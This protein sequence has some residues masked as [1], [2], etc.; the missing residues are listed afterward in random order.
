MMENVLFVPE[1]CKNLFSI[2]QASRHG[3]QFD[4]ASRIGQVVLAKDN[5]SIVSHVNPRNSLY[6]VKHVPDDKSSAEANALVTPPSF[7]LWHQRLGHPAASTMQSLLKKKAVRGLKFP[8]VDISKWVCD[9]C[10]LGNQKKRV[11]F[12]LYRA[13]SFHCNEKVHSDL[14]GPIEVLSLTGGKYILIFV[15]RYSRYIHVHILNE[16]SETGKVIVEQRAQIESKHN[17]PLANLHTDNGGE[18]LDGQVAA[19]CRREGIYH[20]TT[21]TM[22]SQQNGFAK[23]RF[24]DILARA[25]AML[26]EAD[27][28]KQLWSYAV[29]CAVYCMNRSV[30]ANSN[31]TPF[32]LWHGYEPD[33]S[34]MKVFGSVC[35]VHVP[36]RI[37][38]A[39]KNGNRQHKRQKLDIRSIR[40]IFVGY[41]ESKHSY[42]VLDCTTGK[43][44]VSVHITFDESN[45]PAAKEL[46]RDDLKQLARIHEL[47]FNYYSKQAQ[48]DPDRLFHAD[49][50]Q[51]LLDDRE[52]TVLQ[53]FVAEFDSEVSDTARDE[54]VEEYA[55]DVASAN[56][57]AL[58]NATFVRT[59]QLQRHLERLSVPIPRNYA[60]AKGSKFWP[61]WEAAIKS[62][63]DALVKTGTWKYVCNKAKNRLLS[64]TWVFR[65]KER[66]DGSIERF[67]A[68]LV[69]RGYMQVKGLDYSEVCAPVVRLESLRSLLA[70]ANALGLKAHQMDIDTAFLNGV[71][72]ERIGIKLPDGFLDYVSSLGADAS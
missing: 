35:Y 57:I 52:L 42:K 61:H 3:I 28:P 5:L 9:T 32:K 40:G 44:L 11:M 67:K 14:C 16:K 65:A 58:S 47:D 12:P 64:T 41:A 6:I 30:S 51:D 34:H 56:S 49:V 50:V 8:D 68:R 2:P 53:D 54:V 21:T 18:Y 26:I 19:F 43:M 39:D 55:P 38:D 22:T 63:F 66:A 13:P 46:R 33:V 10:Q 24:R 62:E 4:F 69:V 71:L 20:S 15:D 36:M 45:S 60:E 29:E 48:S 59:S 7:E 70:I 1:C 17:R 27:L 25:R 23:V 37:G 72:S 31:T